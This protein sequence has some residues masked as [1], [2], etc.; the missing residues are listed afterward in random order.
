MGMGL[1]EWAFMPNP[2]DPLTQADEQTETVSALRVLPDG[3]FAFVE[4]ALEKTALWR[5]AG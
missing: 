1:L 3:G 4:L 5:I 2:I